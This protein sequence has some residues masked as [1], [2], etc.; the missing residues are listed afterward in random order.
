MPL[1]LGMQMSNITYNKT[2][3]TSNKE[4]SG[5]ILF[6]FEINFN[7]KTNL[8]Q[9]FSCLFIKAKCLTLNFQKH[10]KPQSFNRVEV[11]F[12]FKIDFKVA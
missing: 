10:L 2:I 9:L 6:K 8:N 12:D 5:S 1:F 11:N 7:I 3:Y 4:Q